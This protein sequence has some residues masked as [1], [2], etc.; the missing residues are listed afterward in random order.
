[1][2]DPISFRVFRWVVVTVLAVFTIV[3]SRADS[4]MPSTLSAAW[5]CPPTVHALRSFTASQS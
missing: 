1:M 3:P 4:E 5:V 2:H